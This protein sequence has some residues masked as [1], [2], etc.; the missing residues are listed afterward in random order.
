MSNELERIWKEEVM[1]YP[2]MEEMRK[3][4]SNLGQDTDVPIQI[5][6]KH[7][8]NLKRCRYVNLLGRYSYNYSFSHQSMRS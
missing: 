3:T 4:T 5:R 1:T 6:T 7:L 2:G 8:L